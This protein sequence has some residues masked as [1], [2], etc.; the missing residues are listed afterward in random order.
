MATSFSRTCR[1]LANDTSRYAFLVW[2]LVAA[3]LVAWLCWLIFARVTVYELS[4]SARLEVAQAAHP[5]MAL[6]PAKDPF[7]VGQIG[8]AGRGG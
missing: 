2:G 1:S 7:D 5:I 8:Q 6:L 4:E 3:L